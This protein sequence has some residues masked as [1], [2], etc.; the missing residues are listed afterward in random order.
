MLTILQHSI[1]YF[2][3]KTIAYFFNQNCFKCDY[4]N[5]ITVAFGNARITL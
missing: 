3:K 5:D 1:A 2:F 4:D